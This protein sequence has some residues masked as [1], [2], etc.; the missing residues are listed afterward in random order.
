MKE[1][2]AMRHSAIPEH[3]CTHKQASSW[4]DNFL[5]PALH[6]KDLSE[7]ITPFAAEVVVQLVTSPD[8][9]RNAQEKDIP[10]RKLYSKQQ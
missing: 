4:P 3:L 8:F 7:R 6:G 2:G 10:L 5:P 1:W 9:Q